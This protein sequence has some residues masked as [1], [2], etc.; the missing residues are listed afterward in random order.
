VPSAAELHRQGLDQSNSGRYG[1]ARRI[2]R[3][4][5][6]R[7]DT[8]DLEARIRLSLAYVE[9]EL[10]SPDE[11]LTMCRSALA[12]KGISSEVGGLVH[13]Q[14]GLLQL[15]AGHSNDALREF[16]TA[17]GMLGEDPEPLATAHLNR[18]FLYLLQGEHAAAASDL[19]RALEYG[20]LA[21]QPTLVAKAQHNLGYARLLAGD[22]VAALRLMDAAKPAWATESQAYRALLEQDRAEVLRAAG[23]VGDAARVLRE[24]IRVFG[25]HRL[26]QYQADAELTLARMLLT[27]NPREARTYARR[28]SRRFA[29]RSSPI[30]A[31]RADAVA[32]AAEVESGHWRS[33]LVSEAE[34]VAAQLRRHG[35]RNEAAAVSLRAVQA[36]LVEDDLPA[37]TA[38][39]RRIRIAPGAPLPTRLLHREVRA[40][41]LR[42]M[43]RQGAA[44]RMVSNGLQELHEWQSSF[45]SLD[46]QSSVVG[47]GRN[48]ALRGMSLAIAD[49]RPRVVFEWSERAR[50]LAGRVA[51]VRPPADVHA[52][53]ELSE[54]RRIQRAISLG[55]AKGG[56]PVV[57][58]RRADELRSSIRHRAWHDHGHGTVTEPETLGSLQ[59]R[60][61]LDE[62]V[63]SIVAVEG[64]LHA[65]VVT[66]RSADLIDLGP[67]SLVRSLLDGMQADLD[68]AAAH[69]PEPLR[70]SVH[71]GL[72]QRLVELSSLL[73]GPWSGQ[74]R[75]RRV[76]VVP[77]GALAGTPWTLLPD[78]AGLP[79]TVPRSA[80]EWVRSR[81]Q[82]APRRSAGFVAGPHVDR[83]VDEVKRAAHAWSAA[84]V[85]TG[86]EVVAEKVRHLAAEVDVFHVAAHGR[87]SADNPLF[88]GLELID[89]PWFG[90]DIDQ[91]SSIPSTVI[92]SACELGRSTVRW[93]E[94]TIGMTVAWLHA[95]A[96]CVIASPA[97]VDDDVACE[98]LAGTHQRLAAGAQPAEALAEAMTEIESG[99]AP[100]ISFGSGW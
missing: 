68:M 94:E 79:V 100:F 80:S 78:L 53:E 76:V 75:D 26:G 40:D 92:L 63:V 24:T 46:L 96:R 19:E 69:L 29:A 97:L 39:L 54:L 67:V 47:H 45:G 82:Q 6:A 20:E 59:E 74:V 56:A 43:G 61:G 84:S 41:R 16:A 99:V 33:T 14:L 13:S 64:R 87:H 28:A 71:A 22:L 65:L 66:D 2:F 60:L 37:A 25:I 11:G 86:D 90:Y 7:A 89:G 83:A 34:E 8:P 35:V 9:L 88:S 98:V 48:L 1:T 52:A 42:R 73:V 15:R 5:L 12:L 81:D 36:A 31:L 57:L 72:G 4:A 95:G 23:M 91:L 44:R 62:T 21:A 70:R 58:R 3:R 18:G 10:G 30:W 51:P 49:G 55:E 32:L 27:S 50:A 38:R 85:M 93:G 77:P 17:I